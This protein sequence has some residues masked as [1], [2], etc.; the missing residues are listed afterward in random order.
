MGRDVRLWWVLIVVAA[1]LGGLPPGRA[2]AAGTEPDGARAFVDR[3]YR[4]FSES[5]HPLE[6]SSPAFHSLFEPGLRTLLERDEKQ[7][8]PGDSGCLDFDPFSDGQD[9]DG[10]RHEILAVSGDAAT[11]KARVRISFRPPATPEIVAY[12]LRHTDGAWTIEDISTASIP[13]FRKMLTDC[14]SESKSDH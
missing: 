14:L 6:P 13:S 12:T 11:A 10:L 9:N 7:T 8:Q 5:A 1:M 4:E 3:V 2:G